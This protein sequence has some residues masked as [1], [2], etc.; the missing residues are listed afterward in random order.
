MAGNEPQDS[1]QS[2]SAA[3]P[4]RASIPDTPSLSFV[5]HTA[6][7]YFDIPDPKSQPPPA[8]TQASATA[9]NVN[10]ESM[11]PS[12]TTQPLNLKALKEY[13]KLG[14]T[15]NVISACANIPYAV[16]ITKDG[17]FELTP[18][19]GKS[20]LR[21][22][23]SYL[24]SSNLW[25][26]TVVGWTGE[27]LPALSAEFGELLTRK[28]LL[29]PSS[30]TGEG[31]QL[32]SVAVHDVSGSG[33]NSAF[34]Q[35]FKDNEPSI[36]DI[37]ITKD[38][39]LELETLLEHAF[40]DKIVPVWLGERTDDRHDTLLLKDQTRWKRYAEE[41]LYQNLHSNIDREDERAD[42][43]QTFADYKRLNESVADGIIKAYKPGDIIWIHDYQLMLL[44][45]IVRRRIPSAYIA[46]FHHTN[47]PPKE[48]LTMLPRHTE[49]LKGVIGASVVGVASDGL[50]HYV[51]DYYRSSLKLTGDGNGVVKTGGRHISLI[52]VPVGMDITVVQQAAYG[53]AKVEEY[54]HEISRRYSDKKLIVARIHPDRPEGTD[55]LLRAFEYLLEQYPEWKSRA[56]LVL[57][58]N[59]E[60]I[61]H[62]SKSRTS[63]ADT[64]LHV[65]NINSRFGSL[66]H[67]PIVYL[68]L[69]IP[70]PEYYALLRLADVGVVAS[71]YEGV[72]TMSMEFIV[73]QQEKFSPLF[74]SEK[75]IISDDTSS[76]AV[77]QSAQAA[78]TATTIRNGL[79]MSDEVKQSKH[80]ALLHY[81]S[82]HN[83][84]S[85]TNEFLTK[86]CASFAKYCPYENA[87][88]L[89]QAVLLKAYQSSQTRLFMFDYDGTL[90]PIV[91]DPDAALPSAKLLQALQKLASNKQNKVWII[92]GRSRAFLSKTF[93]DI[94][95]LGLSAE[96]G[97]F[98]RKPGDETWEN[99]AASMDM[100]WKAE[101]DKLFMSLCE[102]TDGAWIERK[103]VAIVWHYRNAIDHDAC[104]AR[105]VEAKALLEGEYLK[106]WD[107]EVMLGK[108]NVE[109]RP[110]FLNK[111][112]MAA[113][114][115]QETFANG[116]SGFVL[117][118]GD[119]TTDEDMFRALLSSKLKMDNVFTC[120]IAR[121]GKPSLG[122][123]R[124]KEP[125]D[126]VEAV[127]ILSEQ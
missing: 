113:R 74:V 5:L 7:A 115:V 36:R 16:G 31:R 14:L 58:S 126:L 125:A 66:V 117:C 76:A 17:K 47:L 107:V 121:D 25:K 106:A 78:N 94:K 24:S 83:V 85:F 103:E 1:N 33:F 44:P 101:T 54:M 35:H 118:A 79:A 32:G 23:L 109:V 22:S 87:A 72:S 61:H 96:H 4:G 56:I 62:S 6:D 3:I 2:V 10:G 40:K 92:S 68:N 70:A 86:A 99:L 8:T 97:S 48:I 127:A 43:A 122:Y 124:V 105:A 41:D 45:E 114:L 119:D 111:G 88:E 64:A 12:E 60:S 69:K 104:L 80:K 51:E 34:I 82:E 37:L 29:G 73:C 27:V 30:P 52:N 42:T 11:K 93:G 26:H 63:R 75:S 13:E 59:P 95:G 20:M 9:P 123:Y 50:R 19:P 120:L 110:R 77:D 100:G 39:R 49:V 53:E 55:F 18:R 57:L 84:A 65:V 112:V 71:D 91:S 38:R 98:L 21:D 28:D 102:K 108:A 46:Y 67:Q 90:T 89:E 15:G 116:T 81:F